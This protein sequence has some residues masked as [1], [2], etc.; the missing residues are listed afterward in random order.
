MC[1]CVCVCMYVCVRPIL[2]LLVHIERLNNNNTLASCIKN[3]TTT[4]PSFSFV[5]LQKWS[6]TV[7]KQS[8]MYTHTHTLT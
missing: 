5:H 4:S 3:K 2:P 7:M 1:K 8:H 6:N